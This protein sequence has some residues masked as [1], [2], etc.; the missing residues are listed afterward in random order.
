V[1]IENLVASLPFSRLQVDYGYVY[2][3]PNDP[4]NPT[5][6]IH[7]TSRIRDYYI[8]VYIYGTASEP[9]T[10]FTSEPPM[11]QEDVIALLATGAT[12]KEFTENNQVLASRATVLLLQDLYHKIFKKKQTASTAPNPTLDRFKLDVGTVDPRTGRE[13]VTGRIKLSDQYE[14]LTGIDVQGDFQVQL[15]YLIRFR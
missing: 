1:R 9:Q 5:L 10:L 2:F 13:E 8:N 3:N 7:G 6:D 14:V 12:T 11:P 15:R 4:F